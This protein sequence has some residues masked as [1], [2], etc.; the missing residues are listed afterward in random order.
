[1]LGRLLWHYLRYKLSNG[2]VAKSRY[3][4]CHH[5]IK[6]FTR[7]A[8]DQNQSLKP[9]FPLTLLGTIESCYIKF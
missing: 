8:T 3:L 2:N 4:R 7:F 1:M 9:Q 5:I 6:Q